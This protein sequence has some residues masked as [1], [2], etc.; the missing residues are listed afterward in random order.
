MSNTQIAIAP[1]I[2]NVVGEK[3]LERQFDLAKRMTSTAMQMCVNT[4]GKAGNE[5]RDNAAKTGF[6][7][8]AMK[9]AWPT[10]DYRPLAEAIA[11]KT[12]TSC[13]ISN[14]ASFESMPDRYEQE[15][16]NLKAGK[17]GGMTVGSDGVAKPGAKLALA[18]ELHNM[19]VAIREGASR[20]S[21]KRKEEFAAEQAK[22]VEAPATK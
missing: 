19:C 15:I 10:C 7:D 16:L 14:R 5:I 11:F 8:A 12:G 1:I 18:M 21:A 3:K 22:K 20:I 2:V 17:N 6:V 13:V 9:A 4:K